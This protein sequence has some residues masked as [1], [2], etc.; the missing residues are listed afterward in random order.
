MIQKLVHGGLLHV[1]PKFRKKN[2][3][4]EKNETKRTQIL[5]KFRLTYWEQHFSFN[6]F[7]RI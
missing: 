2:T 1:N 6:R 7:E 4:F 3:N 5:M